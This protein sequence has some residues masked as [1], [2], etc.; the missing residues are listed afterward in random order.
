MT[1][2]KNLNLISGNRYEKQSINQYMIDNC[3]ISEKKF[4]SL[5]KIIN[6]NMKRIIIMNYEVELEIVKNNNV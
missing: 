2:N 1:I 6:Y 5:F 3:S 4:I